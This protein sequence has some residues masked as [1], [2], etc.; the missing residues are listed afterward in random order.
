[1]DLLG[2]ALVSPFIIGFVMTLFG[3]NF[4]DPNIDLELGDE[5]AKR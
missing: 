2:I 1:M 4:T 3:H 5:N